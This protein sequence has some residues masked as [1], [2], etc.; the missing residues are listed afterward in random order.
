[1]IE[2]DPYSHAVHDDPYPYYKALR[3]HDPAYFNEKY[4]FWILSRYADVQSALRDFKRFSNSEGVSLE[5]QMQAGYPMVLTVDPPVH[6]RIRKVIQNLLMPQQIEK[7]EPG[8]RALAIE[9][10]EEHMVDGKI[11]LLADF[12]VYLPMA[13]I[14]RMIKI[15]RAEESIVRGWTDTLVSREE[16]QFSVPHEAAVA[17]MQLAEYFEHLVAK[18]KNDEPD[19]TLLSAIIEAEKN[20]QL[21]HDEVLGFLILLGVAG[22]ETT[23]K[24]IGNMAYRLWQFKDQRQLL[25]DNPSLIGLAVEETVRFDGSTQL[26]GRTAMEDIELYGKTIKKG[27]RIGLLMISANRDERKWA[28]P[29]EYDIQRKTLGHCGFGFGIHACVGAALA[30]LE[31][32]VAFE[33]ILKRIPNYD[34]VETGLQRMHSPNVRGFTHVPVTYK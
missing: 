8:I 15:P 32:R 14:A 29:D 1:M 24:L 10:L 31:T 9:L 18:H 23:T 25:I 6:T 33:E 4:G 34:I 27:Q 12:A 13:V 30:R 16:G 20:G 28:R 3:D 21:N 7:L 26:L 17:Y 19:N 2:F 11:D 22:N 5:A